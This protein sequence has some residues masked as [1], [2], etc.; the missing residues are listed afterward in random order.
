M[1]CNF[2]AWFATTVD[3]V[4]VEQHSKWSASAIG[5]EEEPEVTPEA[6]RSR[7]AWVEGF[8]D[9][10]Q[11]DLYRSSENFEPTHGYIN[12][13]IPAISSFFLPSS[14]PLSPLAFKHFLLCESL[15]RLSPH[16]V[17]SCPRL[18]A[19]TAARS[20]S[21][22]HLL[23]TRPDTLARHVLHDRSTVVLTFV[24]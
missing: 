9:C 14:P 13:K 21:R 22:A 6:R 19:R 24:L 1:F 2:T 23:S 18:E 8:E 5:Q 4:A 7:P 11:Q 15:F 10:N 17:R 16:L 3:T 12:L 20:T